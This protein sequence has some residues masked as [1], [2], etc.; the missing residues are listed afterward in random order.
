MSKYFEDSVELPS[1]VITLDYD[2]V[3]VETLD[4]ILSSN[5]ELVVLS[6]KLPDLPPS[7]LGYIFF[8][9]TKD[10]LHTVMDI[11]NSNCST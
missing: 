7:S 4:E 9:E 5:S 11:K 6:I 2:S 3:C 8:V 10:E 1:N